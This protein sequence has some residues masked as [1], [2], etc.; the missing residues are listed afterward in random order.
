M[1]KGKR[2]Q[3]KEKKIKK[4]GK[5]NICEKK[6]KKKNIYHVDLGWHCTC[7][8]KGTNVAKPTT[9]I[10]RPANV[11]VIQRNKQN[12]ANKHDQSEEKVGIWYQLE[13]LCRC[14]TCVMKVARNNLH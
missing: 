1:K 4:K 13:D 12:K 14:S 6:T 5:K 3:H 8:I 10:A 9:H 2:N 7:T 11:V